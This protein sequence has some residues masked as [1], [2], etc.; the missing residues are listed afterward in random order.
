MT[1]E[2]TLNQ[3]P[4]SDAPAA[5]QAPPGGGD[6]PWRRRAAQKPAEG[7]YATDNTVNLHHASS[8]TRRPRTCTASDVADR[9]LMA[10]AS[11]GSAAG[12]GA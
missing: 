4:L 6:Q 11:T 7:E 12:G 2:T 5:L 3:A 10:A 8:E 9:A 1:E